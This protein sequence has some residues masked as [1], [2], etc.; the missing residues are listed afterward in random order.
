[1]PPASASSYRRRPESAASQC[2]M[3]PYT[4]SSGH[5]IPTPQ[6]LPHPLLYP[7]V[8]IPIP[9]PRF[10]CLPV[11]YL[12]TLCWKLPRARPMQGVSTHVTNPNKR[13]TCTTV[14][15]NIPETLGMAPSCNIPCSLDIN[16]GISLVVNHCTADVRVTSDIPG[17]P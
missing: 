2:T 3:Q 1:M 12:V 15:E 13:T 14:L 16:R 11:I 9:H 4:S 10:V 6:K 8:V 17:T 5:K 7:A